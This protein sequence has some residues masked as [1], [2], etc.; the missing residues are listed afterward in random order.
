MADQERKDQSGADLSEAEKLSEVP[1]EAV[2]TPMLKAGASSADSVTVGRSGKRSGID[3]R[4]MA[5]LAGAAII[6][7]ALVLGYQSGF[8]ARWFQRKPAIVLLNEVQVYHSLLRSD[9]ALE[10]SPQQA[11]AAAQYVGKVLEG[12]IRHY[13]KEGIAVALNDMGIVVPKKDNITPEVEAE[14]AHHFS[15]AAP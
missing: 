8:L 14:I 7:S 9:P 5:T 6:S 13:Q 1:E 3:W 15:K 4:Y 12:T 10:K 11:Q 2:M